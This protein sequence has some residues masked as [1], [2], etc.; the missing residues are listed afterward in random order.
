MNAITPSRENLRLRAFSTLALVLCLA[1]VSG[2]GGGGGGLPVPPLLPPTAPDLRVSA[3]FDTNEVSASSIDGDSQGATA[4]ASVTVNY[5]GNRDIFIGV[6]ETQGLLDYY[7]IDIT[8]APYKLEMR[9][10]PDRKE[11]TYTSQLKVRACFDRECKEE[12][13]GSPMLLPLRLVVTPNLKVQ[14][15]L[16]L[17]RSG[18][19]AAPVG[20]ITVTMPAG[21]GTLL[22]KAGAGLSE[23]GG[24][25]EVALNG[26]SLTVSTKQVKAGRYVGRV[27]LAASGN[28]AYRAAVDV[29]YVVNPPVGG[30]LG[31]DFSPATPANF[32]LAQGQEFVARFRVQQPTWTTERWRPVVRSVPRPATNVTL[33]DLGNEEYEVHLDTSA[34]APGQR[35][36]LA[37]FFEGSSNFNG[38]NGGRL[39]WY[40]NISEAFGVGAGLTVTV[41][42]TTPPNALRLSAPVNV[43]SGPPQ[44]WS[45]TVT[46]PALRLLRNTGITGVDALEVEIDREAVASGRFGSSYV[47]L[48]IDRAG[49]PLI[50]TLVTADQRLPKLGPALVETLLPGSGVIYLDGYFPP[51]SQ[52]ARCMQITGATLRSAKLMGAEQ[53]V[54]AAKA[55]RLEFDAAVSGQDITVRCDAPLLPT[56]VRLPVASAL[57]TPQAY[58]SLPFKDW[59][60][61]QCSSSRQAL[62]FS[63]DG[64]LAR[65]SFAAGSWTL[66]TQEIEGL[67]DVAPYGDHSFL[68]GIG[69][70]YGWRIDARTMKVEAKEFTN[71]VNFEYGIN[72]DP[73]TAPAMRGLA[74]AADGA[75]IANVHVGG[76]GGPGGGRAPYRASTVLGA[77]IRS[78]ANSGDPNNS[79][80]LADAA[81]LPGGVIRSPSGQTVLGQFPSGKLLAYE[82]NLRAS[83]LWG[84]LPSGVFARAISDD[85]LR[86]I[87]SDGQVRV[88]GVS[89]AGSLAGRLPAGFVV[90]GYGLTGKGNHALVY[91]YRI[92][93]ETAGPR[94]REAAVW[95]F[96]ISN[97]ATQGIISATLLDRL[98]LTDAVGCTAALQSGESCEH[99]ATVVVAEGDQSAFVLGPRGVAALPLPLALV[100]GAGATATS[101]AAAVARQQLKTVGVVK[102]QGPR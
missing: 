18:R 38:F 81:S 42:A 44:R 94:A 21:A 7:V 92:A 49:A 71:M 40:L 39:I 4:R 53:E 52:W 58:A 11:G 85:G 45:A 26:N 46:D 80:E 83:R 5:K 68:I 54:F 51:A 43:F 82:P 41:D 33:R 47:E 1:A 96:D 79:F 66:D 34:Y 99:V 98:V 76:N 37:V 19:E 67:L 9:F 25:F 95:V 59:R 62:F 8:Q 87:G 55:L 57:R 17:A 50:K 35:E 89:V 101:P 84:T 24:A 91:G 28:N 86:L 36:E 61:P 100:V 22:I 30:E 10:K 63:A 60:P 56:Q 48:S 2:C 32:S 29:A 69:G 73:P 27:E 65:W 64:T 20:S 97:A 13:P 23:N 78:A 14:P 90:G 72:F 102:G 75:A 93:G 74:F 16:E 15:S 6:D 77:L 3:S 88:R 31:L 12:A 70:P